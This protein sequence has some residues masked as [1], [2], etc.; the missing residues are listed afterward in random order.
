MYVIVFVVIVG[1]I[2]FYQMYKS[3]K[4]LADRQQKNRILS[5]IGIFLI[6]AA[7]FA[8]TFTLALLNGF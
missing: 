7:A 5:G 4:L 6:S 2:C 8:Y 3:I 1:V